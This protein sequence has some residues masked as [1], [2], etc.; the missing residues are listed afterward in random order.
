[1]S[2]TRS[3]VVIRESALSA[4]PA[5][6]KPDQFTRF[7]SDGDY[8]GPKEIIEI[9]LYHEGK[10]EERSV[11]LGCFLMALSDVFTAVVEI[12]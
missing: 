11:S 1:M 10:P 4:W 2:K 7:C 12:S 9:L 3:T 8:L 5:S 6:L